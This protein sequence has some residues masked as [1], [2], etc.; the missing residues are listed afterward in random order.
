MR[1][2]VITG[3]SGSGKTEAVRALE[4]VG[5]FCVDNLPVPLLGRFVDLLNQAEE[6]SRVAL[7]ID[8]RGGEFLTGC[9]AAFEEIRGVGHDLEIIFF[10]ASDEV[11]IRRF[12]ETRRRHPL[13]GGDL[14]SGL[15]EERRMLASLRGAASRVVDTSS[16]TVHEL[17]RRLRQQFSVQGAHLRVSLLSFGFKYGAPVE[18]DIMLDVRFLPNPYFVEELRPLPGTDSR[19][20]SYVTGTPDFAELLRRLGELLRFVLPLYKREGKA[21]LTVAIGCTGGRHRSV[22]TVETLRRELGQEF[23][24]IAVR[25]RDMERA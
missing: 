17:R 22:A 5:F 1:V 11:L 13:D 15:E 20:L 7:V 12:S 8:V 14:R 4:D 3:M 18:A 21:Y 23:P 25:H 6:A 16:L 19:V 24:Y 2:L 10:D 9:E